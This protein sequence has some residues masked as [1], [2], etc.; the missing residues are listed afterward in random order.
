MSHFKT[1]TGDARL[2]RP[3]Y[4]GGGTAPL[5]VTPIPQTTP[6]GIVDGVTPQGNLAA[7]GYSSNSGIGFTKSFVEHSVVIG[8]VSI[9]ADLTYQ[10]TLSRMWTR[11][12]KYDFYWPA[13]AF[14]GEQEILR[15]EIDCTDTKATNEEVW[16]Y[17]ERWSEY[18]YFPSKITGKM[19]SIDPQS[20]DVWHLSEDLIDPQLNADFIQSN[21]P[22]SRVIAVPSEPEFVFDSYFDLICTRPIPAYSPP[23]LIDHY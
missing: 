9:N 7:I 2:Q 4:L 13:L 20:L 15:Q 12:T 23:G 14:L 5:N 11:Q 10:N 19:R 22:I 6:T 8:Y 3:E 17:N 1:D 21:P 16:G 18:R